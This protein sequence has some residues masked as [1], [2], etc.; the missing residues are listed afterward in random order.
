MTFQT[1]VQNM[2]TDFIIRTRN[3]DLPC[4]HC[5]EKTNVENRTP[6]VAFSDDHPGLV[7]VVAMCNKCGKAIYILDEEEK[8]KVIIDCIDKAYLKVKELTPEL[9]KEADERY[10]K[11]LD[12][13]R[14][15]DDLIQ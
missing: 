11:Y 1:V 12:E 7:L 5:D 3:Q 15:Q 14:S 4:I 2:I 10:L 8:K 13:A 6:F 9:L